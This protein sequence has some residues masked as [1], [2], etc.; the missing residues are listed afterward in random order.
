M[1]SHGSV[2]ASVDGGDHRHHDRREEDEEAPEDERVDQPGA[3]PLEQLLLAED[4]DRLVP[5]ADRHVVEPLH[6]LAEPNEVGSAGVRGGRTVRRR[7]REDEG[8]REGG[9][10]GAHA[11]RCGC[12]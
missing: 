7:D 11:G 8:E 4:D 5:G 3:E 9:E 6:G 1:A 2:G 12:G 10:R